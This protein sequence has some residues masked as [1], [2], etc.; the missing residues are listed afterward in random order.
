MIHFLPHKGYADL[1]FLLTTFLSP[2]YVYW[3]CYS[4]V[5]LLLYYFIQ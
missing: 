4:N 5:D 3:V 1:L 2:D